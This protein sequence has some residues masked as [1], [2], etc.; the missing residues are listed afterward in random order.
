[1]ATP[2]TEHSREYAFVEAAPK[3]CRGLS[4]RSKHDISVTVL[5]GHE[6][7]KLAGDVE[8][9]GTT[10]SNAWFISCNMITSRCPGLLPQVLP[11]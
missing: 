8:Y 1:M 6:D 7:L 2:R 11:P 10:L 9:G 3:C 4:E 5:A